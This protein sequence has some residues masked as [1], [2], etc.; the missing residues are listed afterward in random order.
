MTLGDTPNF[1]NSIA[2]FYVIFVN[3]EEK[4]QFLCFK[5][6][7]IIVCNQ[8]KM[9][10]DI[11]KIC[12]GELAEWVILDAEHAL[13]FILRTFLQSSRSEGDS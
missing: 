13:I 2:S 8:Q 5:E 4:S 6:T 10:S 9:I 7:R 11:N 1:G 3:L 12:Y